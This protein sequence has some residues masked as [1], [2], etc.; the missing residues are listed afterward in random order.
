VDGQLEQLERVTEW[1]EYAHNS[2]RKKGQMERDW[3]GEEEGLKTSYSHSSC[4]HKRGQRGKGGEQD[5]ESEWVTGF[6]Q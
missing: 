1:S 5:S 4:S 2:W 6:G 3:E